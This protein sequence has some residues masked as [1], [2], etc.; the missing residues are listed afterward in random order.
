MAPAVLACFVASLSI[1]AKG[2]TVLDEVV[3]SA[4]RQ[5]QQAFDAPA[6]IN[7]VG[8]ETLSVAGPQVN[9]S[10]ALSRIPGISASN[11]NNYAQDP[12]ISIRGF[13][14]RAAFGVRGIKLVTDGIPAS[15][16]DGQGQASTFALTSTDRIE[17]LRGPLAVL[18][19]N[20]SGGVIQAFTRNASETPEVSLMAYTGSYGLRR[21]DVQF[22][23]TSGQAGL[24]G[25]YS[26]FETDGYR[27]NSAAK[28]TQFNGKYD[29]KQSEKT[30]LSFIVNIWDQP[31]AQDPAGLDA[32]QVANDRTLAGTNTV[33]RRVRKIT[34]QEQIGSTLRHE[35][36]S[37]RTWEGR[38]YGGQRENLQ[39]QNGIAATGPVG[40]WVGLDR[41]YY[42]L[43]LSVSQTREI[44]GIPAVMTVGLESDY[45]KERRQGGA[46]GVG[47]TPPGEKSGALT[48]DEDN[49]AQSRNA[50]VVGN[51]LVSE[52]Y[53]VTAGARLGE[54]RFESQDFISATVD[55]GSGKI[56][57][58]QFSPVLGV[59]RH[60]SPT[61][62]IFLN[63]GRGFETPTLAEIAYVKNVGSN[64][65]DKAFRSDIR[66]AKNEQ[67]ELGFKRLLGDRQSFSGTLFWVETI[68]EIVTDLNRGG[69]ASFKN[70]PKTRR[71]G[72][73][74]S[75][76]AIF[77]KHWRSVV[78]F[79]YID[80]E[81]TQAFESQRFQFPSVVTDTVNSGNKLPA[82]PSHSLFAEL[83]WAQARNARAI[84]QG[85]SAGIELQSVGRRYAND[86]NTLSSDPFETLALRAAYSK[87]VGITDL[88]FFARID[89]ALDE[90]YVG[91]VIVNA[92]NDRVF[93]P[94]PPRNWMVGVKGQAR[95]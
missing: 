91:S 87:S 15:I 72:S 26:Y 7:S 53:S 20:S 13:G 58:S 75:W 50:F 16:P 19:G 8:V 80:A 74:F 66:A 46:T 17:V 47:S 3:V 49:I 21:G 25:D 32:T 86:T 57:Y 43:G 89:N 33:L 61:I 28:R 73:E 85:W 11:R 60:V 44:A 9:V 4:N 81:Y 6:A 92:A 84:A 31:Y 40:S 76:H 5:E 93:E 42:G 12:Q 63:Y 69:Q 56:R 39:Y 68:D 36:S 48:R 34:S 54:V 65:N 94:S 95:F 83:E 88:Q 24:L 45:S 55:V 30:Q 1:P 23:T 51:F 79:T 2:Q 78:A 41:D 27:V 70:A 82:V 71:L 77:S 35:D 10:E 64:M 18:Y 90:K 59:T 29:L 22:S 67:V 38:I 62:N 14:A 37:G 52:R